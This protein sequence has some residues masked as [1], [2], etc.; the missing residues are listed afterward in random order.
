MAKG[1]LAGSRVTKEDGVRTRSLRKQKEFQKKLVE[2]FVNHFGVDS[3]RAPQVRHAKRL[4][5]NGVNLEDDTDHQD[6]F[7]TLH[8]VCPTFATHVIHIRVAVETVLQ[9]YGFKGR[10]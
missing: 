8:Q 9:G 3:P 2:K 5:P 7:Q 1:A 6:F 10:I 4:F